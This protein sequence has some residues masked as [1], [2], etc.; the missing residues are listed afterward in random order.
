MNNNQSEGWGTV[1]MRVP[2]CD[3]RPGLHREGVVVQG[4]ASP[5]NLSSSDVY[6]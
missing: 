5:L 1:V 6:S 3:K 2:G 4:G